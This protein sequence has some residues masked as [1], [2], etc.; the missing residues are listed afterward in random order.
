MR[1]FLLL[2][3]V[4]LVVAL[5][6]SSC[7]QKPDIKEIRITTNPWVGFT[8][9]MYAQQKGWLKETRFKFIWT[10]G[11]DDNA[12]LYDKGLSSGFTATQYEYFGFKNKEKLKPFFLIDRSNGA[13]VILSNLSIDEIKK[14]KNID[15]YYELASVNKDLFNAFVTK[16]NVDKNNFK[17]HYADQNT[18]ADLKI[19]N[20]KMLVIS[21]EPYA[22]TLEKKG[23]K[24]IA[25]T[26]EL[27]SIRV[28]DAIFINEDIGIGAKQDVLKLKS[29]FDDAV[30]ELKKDPKEFYESIKGYLENQSYEE[31]RASLNGIEWLNTNPPNE[32]IEY[33]QKQ[34]VPTDR[35]IR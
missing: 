22:S 19:D 14:Q 9:I 12:K 8:P 24:R 35:L 25:S 23:Y 5:L 3:S 27:D 1:R 18:I 28:I 32:V 6:L 21:Y 15:A 29:A 2:T 11:L 13:D 7:E 30:I 31:F 16:Y 34:N 17:F 20:K 4:A 10:V 26:R 33:L